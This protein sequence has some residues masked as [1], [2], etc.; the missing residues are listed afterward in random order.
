MNWRFSFSSLASLEED[1]GGFD[2]KALAA[3]VTDAND[4]AL[5]AAGAVDSCT[6][7]KGLAA[8][9]GEAAPEDN[10]IPANGLFPAGLVGVVAAL[11]LLLRETETIRRFFSTSS[12]A[13]GMPMTGV[14]E[15]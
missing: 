12:D 9:G 6:P 14:S 7:A 2:A 5:G 4:V 3:G 10:L 1:S 11:P 8:A 15:G 13:L